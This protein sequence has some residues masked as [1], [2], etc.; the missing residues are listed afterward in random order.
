[1]R[2]DNYPTRGFRGFLRDQEGS[3]LQAVLQDPTGKGDGTVP[4]M[5]SSFNGDRTPSPSAPANRTFDG[6]AHQPAYE[7]GEVRTWATAAITAIIGLH[8]KEKHG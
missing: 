1:M 8:F 6:L 5:S 2:S 4:I 3:S 7:D